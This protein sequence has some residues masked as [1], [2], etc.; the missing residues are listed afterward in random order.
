MQFILW[1]L[2][3]FL[4][5]QAMADATCKR[6]TAWPGGAMFDCTAVAPVG[7]QNTTA[8]TVSFE[9]PATIVQAWNVALVDNTAPRKRVGNLSYN[10]VLT[11][12][13]SFGFIIDSDTVLPGMIVLELQQPPPPTPTPPPS[14]PP[15]AVE[16]PLPKAGYFAARGASIVDSNGKNPKLAGLSWFGFETTNRAPHGLWAR[17]YSE[18]LQVAK[19]NGFTFIRLPYSNDI[20]NAAL[21]PNGID[22][23]K[24]PNLRGKTALQVLDLIVAEAKR[25][26]LK[27][28]L[29]RH[30]P[31]ANAQS[32]LWYTPQVTEAKW[33]ADWVT[34]AKRFRGNPTVF[35]FDLHNEPHG[36]A[37]WGAGDAATDWRLAALRAGNAI[38]AENPDVLIV[39][40]GIERVDNDWYW[41]GGNLR[42]AGR[43]PV[44][45]TV[46]GR[47]VYSAH[48]YP[49]SVFE[50]NWFKDASY[51]ANL[52]RVWNDNWGYL[53]EGGIAP[54][55]LGEFGTRLATTRDEQWLKSLVGYLKQRKIPFAFWSLN[56]NSGDTG[57]ILENDWI[58]V[59]RKKLEYLKPLLVP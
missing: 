9:L 50:Q 55:L 29:D 47:V 57:G 10:A 58:T 25:L 39:V 32:E 40:E 6:R 16:V 56:P 19:N 31:N 41:W 35:A 26:G 3:A 52:A 20:F 38:L 44:T 18:L 11:Q 5:I 15:A 24:N 46:P 12:P 59:D 7:F 13:Q 54:V 22:F 43:A 36:A 34:L 49:A 17:S 1:G 51:P 45:L 4:P 23:T 21:V 42:A 33:I 14:P 2:L 28:M 8:W 30:R 27:I 53:V 37:T 48:D